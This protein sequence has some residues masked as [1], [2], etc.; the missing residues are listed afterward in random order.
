MLAIVIIDANTMSGERTYTLGS[1]LHE[2][3]EG[4]AKPK[5]QLCSS[6]LSMYYC[7]ET[8]GLKTQRATMHTGIILV[9]EAANQMWANKVITDWI[10]HW[11]GEKKTL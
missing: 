5:T 10:E 7:P 3:S 6:W 1:S 11:E 2:H 9:G 4:R 8:T